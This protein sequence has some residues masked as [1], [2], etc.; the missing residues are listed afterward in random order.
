MIMA[1]MNGEAYL[2]DQQRSSNRKGHA[3]QNTSKE[4]KKKIEEFFKKT[5]NIKRIIYGEDKQGKG[6]FKQYDNTCAH[7]S[8]INAYF[9]STGLKTIPLLPEPTIR[10]ITCKLLQKDTEVLPKKTLLP[11]SKN[12]NKFFKIIKV[13]H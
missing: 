6:P 10:R 1:V 9:L 4:M 13:S 8:V 11:A 3:N 12:L 2:V 5:F 7:T